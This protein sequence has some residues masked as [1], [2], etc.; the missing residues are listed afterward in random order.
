M[1]LIDAE[2]PA[3]PTVIGATTLVPQLGDH[4]IEGIGRRVWSR[5]DNVLA[6][7]GLLVFSGAAAAI[8]HFTG[9]VVPWDSK[10]HFYPMFRFLAQAFQHGEFPLW[11]PYHFGG[12]PSVADPQSLLFTPTLALLAY[13]A[14]HLSMAGFDV[15]I[16]A[17]LAAGG[18]GVLGLSRRRGWAPAAAV[19]AAIIYM[20]GGSA[21]ARL[22]HTGMIISYG[23]FPL[24]LWAQEVML[25]RRSWRKGLL[26]GLLAALMALGRDQVA[27]LF[28]LTLIANVCWCAWRSGRPLVYL[29]ERW[30]PLGLAALCGGGLL[31]VPALLTMQF[32]G[33]SNRPEFAYAIATAGSL[34]PI[35]FI[36]LFAPDFFGSI[37]WKYDYWGPGSGIMAGSSPDYTDRCI[38]YLYIGSLPV[39]LL[40]WHGL[41]GGRLFLREARF[42]LIAFVFAALYSVGRY[43]PFFGLL[44]DH[45][46]GVRLYRRPADATFL[47][48]VSLAFLSGHLLNQYIANG[49]PS[50]FQRLPR[51][52]GHAL[53]HIAGVAVVSLLIVGL[54]F[55]WL[56]G[57]IVGSLEA[58][59]LSAI[60]YGASVLILALLRAPRWRPA[61]AAILV[62]AAG[63]Q[64][65]WRNA[66]SSLDAEAARQYSV[67]ET[68][69]PTE[70]AGL[71][72][73]SREIAARQRAGARPRVEILGISGAWQ[74]ASMVYG[75]ENSLGY[76]P[77]RIADY[78]KLVGPGENAADIALRRFPGTFRSYGGQLARL[79][80]LE[81]LVVDEPLG[82]MPRRF[83]RPSATL[84]YSADKLFIYRL[85]RA[86]PRAYLAHVAVA[87]NIDDVVKANAFP[88]FDIS[89]EA[90]LDSA[91]LGRLSPAILRINLQAKA[92]RLFPD[93][94][95]LGSGADEKVAIA[96]YRDNEVDLDVVAQRSGVL[97]LHDLYYPGWEVYVDGKRQPLL[98][99][100]MLFRGVE[101]LAGPHKVKFVFRPF[102]PENL[103]AA[104]RSLRGSAG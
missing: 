102:A 91:D 76:N 22:Q 41:G 81:F 80:G 94:P 29:R 19:L 35:N 48:N 40:F 8:W 97:V 2:T 62:I 52:I 7:A 87:A 13:L 98:R 3:A 21:S 93:R 12:H 78:E 70:K 53:P 90:L 15:A 42:F 27:Y 74:N 99:A 51:R 86:A 67:L 57:R 82:R 63:A 45:L 88:E 69:S 58:V 47:L 6:C 23:F 59:T 33:G 38:D 18:F 60:W 73:L 32:L 1:T 96:S 79:L 28:C 9:A 101:L 39:L 34:N 17:H 104:L 5:S 30:L 46:P 25:E 95:I 72:F 92:N 10:N 65:I 37:D 56:Q 55:S 4:R 44:F 77:L 64:L 89:S 61:A 49:L 36:T 26:F 71:D 100:N 43:T 54:H 16:F 24:A 83:P 84:V 75:F 85:G 11:N 50:P 103:L 68:P 66:G 20:L 31:A 14:P